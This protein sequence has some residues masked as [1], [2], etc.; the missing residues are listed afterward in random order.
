MGRRGQPD[1]VG[2]G[3]VGRTAGPG[4]SR[5]RPGNSG[6]GPVGANGGPVGHTAWPD[7]S[8]NRPGDS[9]DG[10]VRANGKPRRQQNLPRGQRLR[11][12]EGERRG[13]AAAETAPGMVGTGRWGHTAWPGARRP[14]S[15]TARSRIFTTNGGRYFM[16]SLHESATKYPFRARRCKKSGPQIPMFF[17][18]S[19]FLRNEVGK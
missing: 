5:N 1:D 7:G 15:C 19:L 12:G 11:A 16:Q 10:P 8:R 14:A 9:G 2:C 13:A 3:P 18:K 4:G 6:C 17:R